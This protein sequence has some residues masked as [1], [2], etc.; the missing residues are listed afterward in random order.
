MGAAVT[1]L[2]KVLG[3]PDV[4][5]LPVDWAAVERQLGVGLP[6]DYKAFADAYPALFINE[7]LRVCHP[8]CSDA[9]RNLLLDAQVRTRSLRE[10]TAEFPE[11]HVYPVYPA[12][13]GLL[14]WGN[15]TSR[16]QCY[17]LTEGHPDDWRVV[18]GEQEDYCWLFDGNFCDFL[19]ASC[20][21]E[22]AHPF[23]GSFTGPLEKVDFVR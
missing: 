15:N 10:L 14:C 19:L 6:A 2:A 8:S 21:G 3:H 16:E 20:R 4:D 18:I 22:L 23:Y 11:M 9:Q 12:P 5:P 1:E 13:G 7:Y 17:W